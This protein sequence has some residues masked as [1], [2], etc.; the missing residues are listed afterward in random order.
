MIQTIDVEPGKSG[1][2]V[3]SFS[4][5][6]FSDVSDEVLVVEERQNANDVIYRL[7]T[8][9]DIVQSQELVVGCKDIKHTASLYLGEI[10]CYILWHLTLTMCH[11]RISCEWLCRAGSRQRVYLGNQHL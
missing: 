3:N 2:F 6:E 1:D 8:M 11:Y 7:D 5:C 10:M 9:G 4:M